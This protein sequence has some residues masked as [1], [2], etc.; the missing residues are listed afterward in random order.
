[1]NF[2][3]GYGSGSDSEEAESGNASTTSA[4]ASAPSIH[5]SFVEDK[6]QAKIDAMKFQP[7]SRAVIKEVTDPVS[8]KDVKKKKIEIL[9]MLPANI[10]AALQ[11]DTM[12]DSDEGN[13]D[14]IV[15]NRMEV[16]NGIKAIGSNGNRNN[17]NGTFA[18]K[19]RSRGSHDSDLLSLL[20]K[21]LGRPA[22]VPN[23]SSSTPSTKVTTSSGN[24]AMPVQQES[25]I[26]RN[27][28]NANVKIK[29]SSFSMP[30]VSNN[31]S[32]EYRLPSKTSNQSVGTQRQKKKN[33]FPKAGGND[34]EDDDGEEN[35]R[36]TVNDG[37]SG[38]SHGIGGSIFTFDDR[39]SQ[40]PERHN[41]STIPINVP[42]QIHSNY[43]SH[44]AAK[45][46]LNTQ[47]ANLYAYQQY[48][49]QQQVLQY[50][51][52]R[53][54]QQVIMEEDHEDHSSHRRDR[55]MEAQLLH[56]NMDAVNNM[57]T[58]GTF[59]A[60]PAAWDRFKYEERQAQEA[61][62]SR[63]YKIGQNIQ[64]SNRLQNRKHQI[65]SLAIA[66]ANTE[67]EML[68]A[69]GRRNKSKAETAAKYGW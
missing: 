30:L 69:K 12:Y 13:D 50:Q 57:E 9:N 39:K 38:N 65:N 1:M 64:Q 31:P 66:A 6:R 60:A 16:E 61:E 45:E 14:E 10:Q 28:A 25:Y 68:D 18:M 49:Y 7:A 26:E 35:W 56:G 2:L 53:Q 15:S 58:S 47:D 23:T 59:V 19:K 8:S 4:T 32:D 43:Q 33:K 52:E 22:P 29:N 34:D 17:N 20:P 24:F 11:G 42:A 48:Q 63:T 44:S 36:K 27:K 62:V 67:L 21:V 5:P 40:A 46:Q 55:R 37:E 51:Q 3:G 41:D 54:Q